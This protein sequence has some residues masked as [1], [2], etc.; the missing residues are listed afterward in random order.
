MYGLNENRLEKT[1]EVIILIYFHHTM[2]H[3][4]RKF[5]PDFISII[6]HI[7]ENEIKLDS[8]RNEKNYSVENE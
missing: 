4:F 6:Y 3:K 7:E 8:K 5:N 1:C 2:K